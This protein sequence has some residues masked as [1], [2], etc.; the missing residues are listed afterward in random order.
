MNI[1]RVT[2]MMERLVPNTMTGSFDAN[3]LS[4]LTS[5]RIKSAKVNRFDVDR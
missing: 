2:F 5:V 4:N 3:Y 1:F